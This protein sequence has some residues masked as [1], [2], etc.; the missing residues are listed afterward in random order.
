MKQQIIIFL[1]SLLITFTLTSNA[2]ISGGSGGGVIIVGT[3]PDTYVDINLNVQPGEW[4][5]NNGLDKRSLSIVSGSAAAGNASANASG[6]VPQGV[7]S[8]FANASNEPLY[9]QTAVATANAS[10]RDKITVVSSGASNK[11]VLHAKL[12]GSITPGLG[13]ETFELDYATFHLGVVTDINFQRIDGLFT[14]NPVSS[15]NPIIEGY[16]RDCVAGNNPTYQTDIAFDMPS[17]GGT[18]HV[19]GSLFAQAT[20][21][22][23]IDFNNGFQFWLEV[24]ENTVLQSLS[25]F[26][27]TPVPEPETFTLLFAGLGLFG[28]V[29]RRNKQVNLH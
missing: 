7:L 18:F 25:G 19:F 20:N 2:A 27:V 12:T 5:Q 21:G 6:D 26:L 11:A 14:A 10:F 23:V 24:P 13:D 3:S 9:S 17:D 4:T 1:S 8:A 16:T 15:C 28:V 29:A 22:A